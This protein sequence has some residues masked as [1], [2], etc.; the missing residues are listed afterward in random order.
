MSCEPPFGAD[1]LFKHCRYRTCSVS[2]GM[3][4]FVIPALMH[5]GGYWG[6]KMI[7]GRRTHDVSRLRIF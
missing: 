2:N 5:S 4:N 3:S 1:S 7:R 6:L